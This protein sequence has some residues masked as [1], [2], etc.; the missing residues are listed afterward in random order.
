MPICGA[1]RRDFLT[2]EE[3]EDHLIVCDGEIS[4]DNHNPYSENDDFDDSD[5][6][7]IDSEE[8]YDNHDWDAAD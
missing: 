2:N 5:G 8:A 7:F 1:C 4:E 3:L 6:A